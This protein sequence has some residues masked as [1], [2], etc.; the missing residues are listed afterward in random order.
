MNSM[1]CDCDIHDYCSEHMPEE[2]EPKS[3][4][5]ILA[6]LPGYLK[7][8]I[9]AGKMPTEV[10]PTWFKS[11]SASIIAWSAEQIILQENDDGVADIDYNRGWKAGYNK[12][13]FDANTALLT[14]AKNL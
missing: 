3:P 10:I 9:D 13:I 1:T 8:A 2:I 7:D 11:A 14:L 6:E 4:E 12:A 5:M